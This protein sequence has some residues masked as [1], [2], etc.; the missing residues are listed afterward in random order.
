MNMKPLNQYIKERLIINK[1][2]HDNMIVVKSFDELRNIIKD[3]YDKLGPGT[4]KYP[5]NFNDIDVSKIDSF[6]SSNTDIG[7]FEETGFKYID[8]SDWDVSN[9]K[10]MNSMFFYCEELKS[11]GDI[12]KWD[13]SNVTDMSGMFAYCNYFNENL[14]SWNVSN[15]TNMSG[16]FDSC[17]YF[18]QNI[19]SWNVSNVTNMNG[20]FNGCEKFNKDL[21]NWDVSSVTNMNAMF[22]NCPI[23]EEY[24]PKFKK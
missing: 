18:N 11:T 2:Y 19:S 22:A 7:I 16:M 14:S 24:K 8:I 15:V 12:S 10:S 3:R 20:M 13:V 17:K 1:D 6:Y 5:I 9:V 23:K 4:K 21:S